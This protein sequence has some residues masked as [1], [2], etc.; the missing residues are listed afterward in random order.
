MWTG[1]GVSTMEPGA[2]LVAGAR[3]D[4]CL[5]EILPGLLVPKVRRSDREI[6]S[7]FVPKFLVCSKPLSHETALWVH[8]GWGKPRFLHVIG[9]SRATNSIV[10][11]HRLRCDDDE[12]ETIGEH[13]VTT[14]E[15]T[16]VD[17]LLDNPE[18]DLPE[19]FLASLNPKLL[20]KSLVNAGSRP[21]ICDAQH[22]LQPYLRRS[23]VI[24]RYPA[25]SSASYY[26]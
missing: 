13:R 7:A 11:G 2:R 21:G 16:A 19:S 10:K 22:R 8:T 15:R 26:R 1:N 25:A 12:L 3:W 18:C 9:S 20:Q 14:P 6:R 23:S 24:S 5:E 4:S 17:L